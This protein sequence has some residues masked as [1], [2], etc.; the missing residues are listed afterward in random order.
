MIE[1]VALKTAHSLGPAINLRRAHR[2]SAQRSLSEKGESRV[3]SLFVRA[4][5]YMLML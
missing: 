5:T 1:L 3:K 2:M 4:P